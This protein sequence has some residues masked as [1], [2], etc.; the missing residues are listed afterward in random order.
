MVERV[1]V[2]SERSCSLGLERDVVA[3]I[4]SNAREGGSYV[5]PGFGCRAEVVKLSSR[6]AGRG[7]HVR[8][9]AEA[10]C[11]GIGDRTPK[12][13]ALIIPAS[14]DRMESTYPTGTGLPMVTRRVPSRG[15]PPGVPE[16][17]IAYT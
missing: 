11:R 2:D 5:G 16:W 8:M 12:P 14:G 3:L 1:Q 15:L 4:L 7:S 17:F 13:L 6:I 10:D 9:D